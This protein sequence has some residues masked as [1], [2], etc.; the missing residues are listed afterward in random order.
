MPA[1]GARNG[2]FR[3]G[4]RHLPEYHIWKAITQRCHNPNS[5]HF[6][7]Y[8]GRGIAVCERWRASFPAFLGDM[9]RRPSPK[10]TIERKDNGRGYEPSNCIWATRTVQA[11]NTRQNHWL[12]FRG[13]TKCMT[14]WARHLGISLQT[15]SWR[16]NEA[17]WSVER[18][19]TSDIDRRPYPSA[20]AGD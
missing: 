4:L 19:L 17:G 16:L 11:R 18:A 6:N 20:D 1:S 15:L 5:M 2:R 10:H 12:T 9:G 8:G 7:N 14:D 13:E 3:H